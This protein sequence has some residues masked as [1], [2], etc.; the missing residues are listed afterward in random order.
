MD[1]EQKLGTLKD[2]LKQVD[3]DDPSALAEYYHIP[4][5]TNSF[6][7]EQGKD[8]AS[9]PTRRD[10]F[11]SMATDDWQFEEI[12][13]ILGW[14]YNLSSYNQ[15][16]SRK[17]TLKQIG[18]QSVEDKFNAVFKDMSQPSPD[19]ARTVMKE[20]KNWDVTRTVTEVRGQEKFTTTGIGPTTWSV[21]LYFTGIGPLTDQHSQRALHRISTETDIVEY[22]EDV[23]AKNLRKWNDPLP[24]YENP[25]SKYENSCGSY[26]NFLYAFERLREHLGLSFEE[27]VVLLDQPLFKWGRKINEGDE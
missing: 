14:K 3:H 5:Y 25:L 18:E 2:R 10:L 9:P 26:K 15:F 1:I 7:W 23:H 20:F 19:N 4:Q 17:L 22:N 24:S 8:S 13:E 21:F 11:Q 12:L 27:G 16:T 6:H